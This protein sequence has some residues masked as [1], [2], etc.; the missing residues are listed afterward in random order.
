[1]HRIIIAL[2][3]AGAGLLL[4][5]ALV[6]ADGGPHGGYT[7]T[8]EACGSCHRSHTAQAD[9]LLRMDEGS[10]CLFCHDGTGASND[11]WDGARLGGRLATRTT[12]G[13]PIPPPPPSP[14]PA[15]GITGPLKGGGFVYARIDTGNTT[16]PGAAL[17][18]VNALGTPVAGIKVTSAHLKFGTTAGVDGN[19]LEPQNVI[20]GNGAISATANPG[21]N[22]ASSPLSCS[23]CH[24]PHGNGSY[25]ILRPIPK[26]S[27]ASTG[28]LLQDVRLNPQGTPVAKVYTTTNYWTQYQTAADPAVKEADWTSAEMSNWCS[29]CHTRY[30][31]SFSQGSDNSG[32]AIFRY[33]HTSDG[34]S[35]KGGTTGAPYGAASFTAFCLQCH[36]AH[37]SNAVMRADRSLAR[38]VW[39]GDTEGRGTESTLLK[40]DGRGVCVACHGTAPGS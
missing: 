27:D 31:A 8:T 37:G 10:L 35:S 39:P 24:N 34:T 22:I 15:T 2:I 26:Q 3:M 13:L 20:W 29:T 23:D 36:V 17:P 12:D 16:T 28:Q 33:R 5:V 19:A 32:D 7:T 38:I 1:M 9:K 4:G 21:K 14:T 25:R 30:K 40:I 6:A 18:N 11:T